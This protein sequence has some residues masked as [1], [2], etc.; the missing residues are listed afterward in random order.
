LVSARPVITEPKGILRHGPWDALFIALALAQGALMLLAP[1]LPLIAIGLWWNANTISH[2]F[3]HGPFFRSRVWNS[4]FSACLSLL[5]GL[6]QRLWRDRHLAHHADSLWRWRRS[7][8]LVFETALVLGFWAALATLA[9]MFLVTVYLPG[10]LI[11]LALCQFQGY[12]EHEHGTASHY[13]RLYNLLFFNDGYHVEHHARPAEFWR[14]LPKQTMPAAR[15]S[16]WPAVL[17]WL[18]YCSLDGLERLVLQSK[19]L[20]QFVVARHEQAFRALLPKLA[21]VRR[22]VIVGGGLFPRTALILQ[23]LLPEAELTILE[24]NLENLRTAGDYLNGKV[25]LLHEFF[26]GVTQPDVDLLV[27]P[28]AFTGD[29]AAIYRQPPAPVVLVHDWFWR[30]RGSGVVVALTLLKRL[31][32]VTR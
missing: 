21:N 7:R 19:I 17:R 28:L 29:R 12:F 22:V 6:P 8:Q 10:F 32:L 30:R 23:R 26:A 5:L 24:V 2:N 14:N 1:S 15:S 11:G 25:R 13:G 9:P 31:N 20:Q 4:I 3:I 18:E 16:R 27:V